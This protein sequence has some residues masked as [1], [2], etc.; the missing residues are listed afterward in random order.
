[1]LAQVLLFN[2]E[3]HYVVVNLSHARLQMQWHVS[4][5]AYKMMSPWATRCARDWGFAGDFV[6]AMWLML[7]QEKA[8]DYVIAT[9][10]QNTIGDLCRCGI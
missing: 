7:Q 5:W 1:M 4:N 8:S 2:H 6:E 9:G 3:S 10:Q